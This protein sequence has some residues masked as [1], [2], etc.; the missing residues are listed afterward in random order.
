MIDSVSW[1]IVNQSNKQRNTD[2]TTAQQQPW[3]R[4][5][6]VSR[7]LVCANVNLSSSQLQLSWV[8][9]QRQTWAVAPSRPQAVLGRL[10]YL[11]ISWHLPAKIWVSARRS[12]Q[13]ALSHLWEEVRF[14]FT[15]FR[16]PATSANLL[17]VGAV[18]IRL[19][20]PVQRIF[21][22][23]HNAL[24]YWKMKFVSSVHQWVNLFCFLVIT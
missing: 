10:S 3:Q 14:V 4:G 12:C 7:E 22:I 2:S 23:S 9:P 11:G 8:L 6:R 20:S 5:F 21:Q 16:Q 17:A 18:P 13:L 15:K 1:W 24:R 19:C